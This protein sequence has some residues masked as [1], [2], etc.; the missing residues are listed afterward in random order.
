MARL[1]R[2]AVAQ[3]KASNVGGKQDVD[4][5]SIPRVDNGKWIMPVKYDPFDI[6]VGEKLD[7]IED[8]SDFCA[9]R[10]NAGQPLWRMA[11]V[12]QHKVFASSEN[13]SWE[14]ITYRSEGS[15]QVIYREQYSL[16][17]PLGSASADFL[18]PA[19]KGW[20]HISESGLIDA[21]PQLLDDAEQARHR[22]PVD[23]GVYDVVLSAQAMAALTGATIGT[24]TEL[25]RALGYE[26]DAAGTSYIDDPLGMLGTYKVGAPLLN[27]TGDRSTV[28]G[29]A[30]VKWD[31]E[32]V[33]PETFPI[34]KDGVLVDFQTTREQAA[35]LA[36]YYRKTGQPIR[37]RG[38]ANSDSA[39]TVTMQHAPNLQIV[40]GTHNT[41]FND[42][43]ADTKRGIAM[44]D[45]DPGTD[46]QQKNGVAIGTMRYIK[47]GK[48]GKF[49]DKGAIMFTSSELWKNLVAIGGQDS[50]RWYGQSEV[51][52]QPQQQTWFSVGAVPG[53]VTN[54]KVIDPTRKA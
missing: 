3:A 33:V 17:L 2:G 44:L 23:V 21:I 18:T 42:L 48:L 25:D 46:Q 20:E 11:F 8:A 12:R 41:T 9:T 49:V 29:L 24:A 13:S 38:C 37:S 19:G 36:P 26:A 35:W 27:V 43:V 53:K 16:D 15:F 39:Q 28:G 51:K 32:A 22:M 6:T 31:D 45:A 10:M 34:V 4:L 30:T 5:G 54:A 1:G 50:Q 40:P 52:G 14:Q 47:D 7:F